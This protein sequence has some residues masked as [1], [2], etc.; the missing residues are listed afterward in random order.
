PLKS[1][2]KFVYLALNKP[3]GI[4]STTDLKDKDNIID[5]INYPERIFPIGRL[6]KASSGLILLTNDGDIVN[7]ILREENEHEKE[8]IVKVNR[9]INKQ[10]LQKM[11]KG[12]PILG[13]VT[14]A[15]I[16]EQRGKFVFKIILTQGLNRQI[17]RMC[18]YLG[19]KVLTLK[20]IRV[21]NI[22]LEG[23]KVGKW[24]KLTKEE[25]KVLKAS[26]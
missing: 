23:L 5:F 15:C 19:Y 20:R 8:Y 2:P 9:P 6:D 25:L 11:R 22:E 1:K 13:T 18:E 26:L 17:R 3:P 14:K 4:T 10:F 16:V 12:I 21:M 7:Q 24:R